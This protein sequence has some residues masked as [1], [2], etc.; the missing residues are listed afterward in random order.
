M[1]HRGLTD[2]PELYFDSEGDALIELDRLQ[3]TKPPESQL[4]SVARA[5]Q[6]MRRAAA[7][8]IPRRGPITVQRD[9]A[10]GYVILD[11]N[12]TYG[13]ARR[14]GWRALPANIMKEGS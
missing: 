14:Y 5:E 10:S 9:V 4:G 13:V 3:P 7:G 12:A 6:L 11:G 8:E 1:H 2:T